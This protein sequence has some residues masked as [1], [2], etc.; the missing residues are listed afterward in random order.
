MQNEATIITKLRELRRARG[1]TVD[2]L[3][4]RIGENSQK[5]G[6]IERGATNL[7]FDYLMRVSKAL[8]T[9]IEDFLREDKKPASSHSSPSNSQLLSKIVIFVEEYAQKNPLSSRK[10]AKVISK[11]HE[12]AIKFPEELHET[13]VSSLF[14]LI[15]CLDD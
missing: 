14:E 2:T 13:I 8:E 12:V 9:P 4:K 3:A 15:S 7:T 6:R 11:M 10:K 1:L 5:V